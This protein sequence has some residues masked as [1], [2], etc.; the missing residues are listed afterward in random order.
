LGEKKFLKAEM[1]TSSSSR[2]KTT[3]RVLV[4]VNINENVHSHDERKHHTT[5]EFFRILE[6]NNKR[7]CF[8]N[9]TKRGKEADFLL[10]FDK[11][12]KKIKHHNSPSYRGLYIIYS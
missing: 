7:E 6:Q 10:F 9:K 3:K 11:Q 5:E 12:E 8:R 4:C 1:K 2:A